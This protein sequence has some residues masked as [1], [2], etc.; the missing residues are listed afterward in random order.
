MTIAY[1]QSRKKTREGAEHH[2]GFAGD[3][4]LA[5]E[6]EEMAEALIV[7]D[8]RV[9]DEDEEGEEDIKEEADPGL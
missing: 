5:G 6:A 9:H 4:G 7:G 2:R 3:D 1:E 8:V